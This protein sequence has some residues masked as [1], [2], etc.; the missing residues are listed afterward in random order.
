MPNELINNLETRWFA[1][2]DYGLPR[3]TDIFSRRQLLALLT[4]TS[5]VHHAH[6]TMLEEGKEPEK[7]AAITTYLGL[8]VDR[9]AD[10]NSTVCRWDNSRETITNTYARQAIPMVWDFAEVNPFGGASGDISG[11]LKWMLEAMQSLV[12]SGQPALVFRTSASQLPLEDGTLDAVITDPPY[13]D[14]VSYADLSDFFYVWLKRSIGFLYPE[15]FSTPL[16]PKKQ[17]AIMATYRHNKS[18]EM[19]RLSYETMMAQ[20]FSEAHR[21]LKP[22]CSSCLC[23]CS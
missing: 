5:E 13:Y 14:N 2:P 11:A 19:A 7:A 1:P 15:H 6:N 21:V 17:E 12:I 18:K 22:R 9:L 4:F 3:F 16:T 10:R 8:M 23:L 20:A